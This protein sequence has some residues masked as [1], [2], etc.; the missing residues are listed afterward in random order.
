MEEEDVL[1]LDCNIWANPSVS[2]VSWTQNGSKVDLEEGGFAIT[3]D[4]FNSKLS[5]KRAERSK[6]EG[7]YQCSTDYS[8]RKYTKT[9]VVK[10]TGQLTQ[11]VF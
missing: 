11:S 8:N 4:G 7:R 1:V 9:F 10:L 5:A 2:A 6:H 3:N